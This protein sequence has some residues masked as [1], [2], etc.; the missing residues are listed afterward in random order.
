ME[1]GLFLFLMVAAV[2]LLMRLGA[3]HRDGEFRSSD[4]S[5]ALRRKKKSNGKKE[6]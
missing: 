4:V 1:T 2:F 6:V 5:H 3:A